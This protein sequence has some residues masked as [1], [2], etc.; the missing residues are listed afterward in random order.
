[1][2]IPTRDASTEAADLAK[3]EASAPV[4]EAS[5]LDETATPGPLAEA[6]VT[7]D[8][9]VT[10]AEAAIPDAP[11]DEV[12]VTASDAATDHSAVTD[13]GESCHG[14]VVFSNTTIPWTYDG[15]T[16]C[17][18]EYDVTY[19]ST[20]DASAGCEY[21]A[22]NGSPLQC[23][24]RVSSPIEGEWIFSFGDTLIDG[25]VGVMIIYNAGLTW[26]NAPCVP[27]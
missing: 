16:A 2:P 19:C 6:G 12:A 18:T 15:R 8:A 26:N 14:T 22:S 3:Q 20:P 21:E 23:L 7:R 4:T 1:L 25:G 13:A 9:G 27:Q 5:T 24:T 17:V 10:V 11:G